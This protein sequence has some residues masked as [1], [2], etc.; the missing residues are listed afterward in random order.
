MLYRALGASGLRISAVALGC[1]NVGGLFTTDE[2]T[3]AQVEAV[4]RAW[5]LGINWFD[6][7]PQYGSGHSETN[8][9]WA[10]R[11][12]GLADE[13]TVSTKVQVTEE[14]LRDIPGAIMRSA[15]ASLTRLEMDRVAVFQLHNPIT[16]IRG[17]RQRALGM[18]D[19]LGQPGVLET[20]DRLRREGMWKA[21]GIT[22]LGDTEAIRTVIDSGG[23]HAAQ[24]YYNL[25]NPTAGD[26]KPS[27]LFVHDYGEILNAT[28]AQ[29]MGVL[30]IRVMAA[31]ALGEPPRAEMGGAALSPG[32]DFAEDTRRATALREVARE[33]ELSLARAA[34]RFA[35]FD[36][37]VSTALIGASDIGQME[38]AVEAV[39]EGPLPE[40]FIS[41]WRGLLESDFR[42]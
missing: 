34:M 16:E 12:A 32:S 15:E 20:M 22:A 11:E 6:T 30:G 40:E 23:F 13:A 27:G 28:H 31:G 21:I 33:M 29:K 10:L 42:P 2:G 25:L 4:K 9:G 24:V 19:V 17:T 38:E 3:D 8:L 35:A 14:G 5:E 39:V 37:R 7:A 36:E 18:W 26:P 41:A 1:G